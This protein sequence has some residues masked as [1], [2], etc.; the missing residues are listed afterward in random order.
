MCETSVGFH[1]MLFISCGFIAI[2]IIKG[3]YLGRAEQSNIM[4]QRKPKLLDD[5][6]IIHNVFR[7]YCCNSSSEQHIMWV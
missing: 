1:D 2:S 5:F 6:L 4:T 3:V 7:M